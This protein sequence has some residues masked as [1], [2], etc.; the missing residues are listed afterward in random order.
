MTE[1]KIIMKAIV[2]TDQAAGTAGMKLVEWPKPQ[3]T[4]NED[5]ERTSRR[6]PND[7]E[8]HFRTL[9]DLQSRTAQRDVL[10]AD[11]RPL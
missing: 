2:V 11:F 3:A 4:I 9:H 1:E 5:Q 8:R 6:G 7:P 10:V